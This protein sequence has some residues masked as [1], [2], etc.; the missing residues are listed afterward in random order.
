MIRS[1]NCCATGLKW[2]SIW[3]IWLLA[4]VNADGILVIC[5]LPAGVLCGSGQGIQSRKVTCQYIR[6]PL[7]TIDSN[8]SSIKAKSISET[9]CDV[10]CSSREYAFSAWSEWGECVLIDSS[11]PEALHCIIGVTKQRKTRIQN[12][13]V[14]G[15]VQ[16][17]MNNF[18]VFL[19]V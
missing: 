18:V 8:F 5:S 4:L 1:P 7:D 19:S 3:S 13:V 9:D 2:W 17:R 11:I 14:V 10:L 15:V 6:W 12:Q 16:I